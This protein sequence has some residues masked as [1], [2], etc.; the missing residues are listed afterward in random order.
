[1][2]IITSRDVPSSFGISTVGG[3]PPFV[4]FE[5]SFCGLVTA[6]QA[7]L[8]DVAAPFGVGDGY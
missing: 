6:G 1:M 7:P 3:R 2:F 8:I 4:Q 5:S